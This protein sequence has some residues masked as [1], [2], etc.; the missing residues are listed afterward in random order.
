V[1]LKHGASPESLASKFP[2]LVKTYATESGQMGD[3]DAFL[4]AGNHWGHSIIALTD[5][6]LHGH[7]ASQLEANSDIKYVYIFSVIGLFIFIIACINFMNL[8]TARSASRAK[9]V[10]VRKMLGSVK[11]QLVTQFLFESFLVSGFAMILALGI[12]ELLILFFKNISPNTFL[13]LFEQPWLVPAMLGLI[14]IVGIVVGIYP[15][16]Y[17]T[18]FR[19]IEVLKGQMRRGV[20]S[21][22]VR[23]ILVV[24]QFA[25]S[26]GLII[27]TA[28]V[29]QQ[30][31]FMQQKDIGFTKENVILIANTNEKLGKQLEAF[32]QALQQQ[33]Q[34][35]SVSVSDNN[36]AINASNYTFRAADTQ[37]DHGF[38]WFMADHD[39]IKTIG[40]QLK[41]GRWFLPIFQQMQKIL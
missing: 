19:P 6:H 4:K 25:V 23:N 37:E 21:N 32:K 1:V 14:L 36:Q 38:H 16:F 7:A 15:A 34:V 41:E 35:V 12:S 33:P 28:I 24:F 22:A 10:G 40:L 3:Y 11:Q 8:A 30:L 13:S 5:I 9:E 27:C 18:A 20:K 2:A 26:I 17:L 31:R 39:Y 29:Y